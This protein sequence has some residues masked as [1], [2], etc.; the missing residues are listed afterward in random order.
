VISPATPAAASALLAGLLDAG[1]PLVEVARTRLSVHYET[2]RADVPVLCV[3]TPHAVRL[4]SSVVTPVVPDGP[5]VVRDGGLAGA[6]LVWQVTRWWQP[7]RPCGLTPPA[8]PVSV[9]GVDVPPRLDPLALVGAGDG[10]TPA[11]D[12][13]LAGALVAA[14]AT[15]HPRLEEWR[16]ATRAALARR[17]TT[18]VSRG[19]LTHALD[20]WATPELADFVVAVCRRHDAGATGRLLAVG[21]SSGTA[22]A[23]GVL[24]VLGGEALRGAA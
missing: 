2:G 3:C 9:P 8:G 13:V 24:H 14:S 5:L 22:L 10:L 6:D 1:G 11:G 23:A 15:G 16:A 12:D 21:H 4:P 17:S 18:A 19:L 7:P 20:G